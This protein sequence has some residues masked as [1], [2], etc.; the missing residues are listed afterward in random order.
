M[1]TIEVD[2]GELIFISSFFHS[3]HVFRELEWNKYSAHKSDMFDSYAEIP[4][5]MAGSFNYYF[6]ID[7]RS[8]EFPY[9]I[10]PIQEKGYNYLSI[11]S[12]RTNGL[13]LCPL[14]WLPYAP[15][16]VEKAACIS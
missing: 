12:V 10:L 1:L 9:H 6:T 4:I 11:S 2:K 8:V 15:E 5:I 13:T 3:R 7:G 14:V 16:S